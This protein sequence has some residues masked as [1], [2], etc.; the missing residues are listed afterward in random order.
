MPKIEINFTPDELEELIRMQKKYGMDAT[1]LIKF[2]I[3][4]FDQHYVEFLW[5]ANKLDKMD[6]FGIYQK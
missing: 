4:I 1:Q 5:G 2:L 3:R 6:E